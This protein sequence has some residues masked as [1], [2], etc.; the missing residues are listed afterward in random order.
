MSCRSEYPVSS[1]GLT[2][3]RRC[4]FT[5]IESMVAVTLL[6]FIGASVWLVVERCMI[7]AADSV[8]RMRAF[9]IARENM[10][11]LLGA[12]SVQKMTEYG[13]NEKFP[14]IR[15]QTTVESFYEPIGSRMWIRAVC[16]AEYTN[17]AGETQNVE[18]THWLTD[19]T[20]EQI[21]QLT[22]YDESQKQS[23]AQYI[24]G[25][26]DLA[27]QY[28]GVNVE[29]IR[30]W[31]QNNMPTFDGDFLKPW[32]DLYLTANGNPTEQEKQE[33]ISRYPEL[34]VPKQ[35]KPASDDS[36]VPQSD[37]PT[38]SDLGEAPPPPPSD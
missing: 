23:L 31:V 2:L 1:Q 5:L 17:S 33:L 24:I 21:Q 10:E 22:Q 15:W 18:L 27:A 4:A 32:L 26:E 19:L 36:A 9:E 34:G 28:A 13:I 38:T 35:S 20:D 25:T 37:L 11:Q 29:T 12:S 16:S 6:A 7:S 14:D 30:Q 3:S 8:Q